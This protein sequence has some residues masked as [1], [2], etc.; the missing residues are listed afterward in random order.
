ML[1]RNSKY[2]DDVV[3]FVG[4]DEEKSTN[5]DVYRTG[6]I[7]GIKKEAALVSEVENFII[8]LEDETKF[9]FI[10]VNIGKQIGLW[11]D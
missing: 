6:H 4:I 1:V 8:T 11:N 2:K 7:V 10:D 3:Y 5:E 9:C